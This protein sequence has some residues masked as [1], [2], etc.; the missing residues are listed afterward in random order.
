MQWSPVEWWKI[1]TVLAHQVSS[2]DAAFHYPLNVNPEICS[3][4]RGGEHQHAVS[5]STLS[6]T[7]LAYARAC[8]HTLSHTLSSFPS[9]HIS[10]SIKP[11]NVLDI[12]YDDMWHFTNQFFI[13]H[14]ASTNRPGFSKLFVQV[15]VLMNDCFSVGLLLNQTNPKEA[16]PTWPLSVPGGCICACC[17]AFPFIYS[18]LPG[19][20]GSRRRRPQGIP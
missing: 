14:A 2:C 4:N 16:L 9:W 13:L 1:E 19:H 3:L 11:W 15:C 10:A 6:Q 12:Q 18:H 5:N 7:L 17:C 20:D 8:T